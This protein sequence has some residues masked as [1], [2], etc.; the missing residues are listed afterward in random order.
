MGTVTRRTVIKATVL[1]GVVRST[2]LLARPGT[3]IAATPT[4]SIVP[5]GS[6]VRIDTPTVSPGVH[7]ALVTV[8]ASGLRSNTEYLVAI[9]GVTGVPT[10]HY[11]VW[12]DGIGALTRK[13]FVHAKPGC[14]RRPLQ[15][16]RATPCERVRVFTVSTMAERAQAAEHRVSM[17]DD[18]PDTVRHRARG[19]RTLPGGVTTPDSEIVDAREPRNRRIGEGENTDAR[20]HGI[21]AAVHAE[22][23]E[24]LRTISGGVRR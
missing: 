6:A 17:L 7:G 24:K 18:L 14:M 11:L 3:A 4:S 13:L 12:T 8:R 2:T 19:E 9:G 1:A 23:P 16:R 20:N 21:P 10:L 15:R 22:M 5:V